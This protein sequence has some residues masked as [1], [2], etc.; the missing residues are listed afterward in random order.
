MES[1]KIALTERPLFAGCLTFLGGLM[2]SYG[3]TAWDGFMPNM[4]TGNMSRLGISL[5]NGEM[6]AAGKYLVLILGCVFGAAAGEAIKAKLPK[7][8]DADAVTLGILALMLVAVGLLPAA[9]PVILASVILTFITGYLF[10]LFRKTP[11]GPYSATVCTGNLRSMGQYL[12]GVLNERTAA[13]WSRLVLFTLV[14]F[15]FVLGVWV[16]VPLGQALGKMAVIVIAVI[17]L[18]LMC[19]V[20]AEKKSAARRA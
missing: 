9:V 1:K 11:W 10:T 8:Y 19:A 7:K 2:N 14:V 12:F 3:Y 13:A 4:H 5:A 18:A 15:S 6:G 20:V 17:P 16:G